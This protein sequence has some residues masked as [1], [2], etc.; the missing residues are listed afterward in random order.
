MRPYEYL[1]DTDRYHRLVLSDA[2][3]LEWI[4]QFDGSSASSWW[5]PPPISV[6]ENKELGNFPYLAGNLPFFDAEAWARTQPLLEG[7]VE[8]L[9]LPPPRPDWPELFAINVTTV[10]DCLDEEASDL[11][12]FND[13]IL[14]IGHYVLHEERLADVPI[15]R[16]PGYELTTVF[17]S[18]EFRALVDDHGLRGL[19]WRPLP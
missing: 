1:C 7:H 14:G 12:R 6:Y 2:Q 16:I 11:T 3:S 5:T 4:N 18:P 15:F 19:R 8:A 17:V 10:V 13:L 9:P